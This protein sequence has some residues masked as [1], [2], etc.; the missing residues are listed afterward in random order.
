MLGFS[1]VSYLK[2]LSLKKGG[3]EA[4]AFNQSGH[5][6]TPETSDAPRKRLLN[7]V[8]EMSIAAGCPMPKVF[9]MTDDSINAFAAG[10]S[11]SDAV[12]GVTSKAIETLDRDELQAVIAH[13]FSHVMQGDMRLNMN[14]IAVVFSILCIF[15]AG[16]FI[17]RIQGHSRNRNSAKSNGNQ[18]ALAGMILAALGYVGYVGSSLIKA[19]ISRQREFFADAAAVQ[20]TRNPEGLVGAFA[21]IQAQ[22]SV[23]R[24]PQADEI[25][26][27]FFADGIRKNFSSMWSTHP[28]LP[29]RV[30]RIGRRYL[31]Q[32]HEK[33]RSFRSNQSFVRASVSE[34]EKAKPVDIEHE[35]MFG[36]NHEEQFLAS[37]GTL[38]LYAQN[39]ATSLT[40]DKILPEKDLRGF[41][42]K[43]WG[44]FEAR[45][46][47]LAL[48][49]HENHASLNRQW[50]IVTSYLSEDLQKLC[51]SVQRSLRGSSS[52]KRLALV[53]AALGPLKSMTKTQTREFL[54]VLKSMVLEDGEI[55]LFEYTLFTIVKK[56]LEKTLPKSTRKTVKTDDSLQRPSNGSGTAKKYVLSCL[57][58]SAFTASRQTGL[59][60]E[61]I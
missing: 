60:S 15:Q 6:V 36:L 44:A 14:L 45:A 13:E 40:I 35:G 31:S 22:G 41:Y 16:R 50:D 18:L 4:L 61:K 30:E 37:I 51:K 29:L 54:M 32:F 11:T 1:G 28:K 21:K 43:T 58:D 10:W 17:M 38:P 7:I 2:L 55:L 47:I 12:V 34:S 42:Q 39:Q 9:E 27:M 49:I 56:N 33:A 23:I 3:G 52:R 26:H 48:F 24:S 25:S 20:F 59:E 5:Y 8:E 53:D 46:L 57:A 19:A